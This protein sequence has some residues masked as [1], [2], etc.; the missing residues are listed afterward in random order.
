MRRVPVNSRDR[1]R[2]VRQVFLAAAT[3]LAVGCGGSGDTGGDA[4][5]GG[6]D[7]A[8]G[9]GGGG[10]VDTFVA[11]MARLGADA[12]LAIRILDASPAPPQRGLN[13]W[14]IQ[15]ND[16]AGAPRPGCTL[17]VGLFMPAH[18][19]SSTTQ[20][21]VTAGATAGDY[22][23]EDMNLFMP[24]V[25]EITLEPTCGDLTDQVLFAFEI[26]R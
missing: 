8:T 20:P 15:V 7:G 13:D 5:P 25:W 18:G 23:I 6:A 10:G 19:H 3:W 4:A 14:R 16:A 24:G 12:R 11:G 21:V 9:G 2:L 22:R 26:A 17:T 1:A